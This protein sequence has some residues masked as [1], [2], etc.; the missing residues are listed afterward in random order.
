VQKTNKLIKN[1]TLAFFGIS[2]LIWV[3]LEVLLFLS[4]IPKKYDEVAYVLPLLLLTQIAAAVSALYNNYLVYF[5]RTHL[6]SITGLIIC[7]VSIAASLILIPRWGIYGAAAAAML[8]NI[9][10]FLI[11]TY[12]AKRILA[13]HV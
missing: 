9:L 11:Y 12:L 1:L 2:L 4:I 13:R 7:V 8:S 6:I 5:E 3:F 10:Y